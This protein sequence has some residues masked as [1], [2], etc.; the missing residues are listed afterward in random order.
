MRLEMN[1]RSFLALAT[2]AGGLVISGI[3]AIPAL[4]T[5]LSPVLKKRPEAL[6]VP[7]GELASFELEGVS[8][9]NVPIPRD[10]WA[11]SP[12]EKGVFV[13]RPSAEEVV[14]FSRNCTD[15][16]CPV[17]WD[18]GSNWFYCPCHGGIFAQDGTNMAGPPTRPLYRYANR[19]QDGI[20][21]I[22]LLS[23]P[24]MT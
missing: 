17:T 23:L 14:V 16:S 21:E 2:A 9:A 1:R 18:P 4:L 22:D 6:W 5:A 11:T 24:P 19:V 3:V 8:K 20:L 10:D 13:W 7:V 12:E 15:L